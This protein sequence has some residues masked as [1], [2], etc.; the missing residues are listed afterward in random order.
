MTVSIQ[1]AATSPSFSRHAVLSAELRAAFPLARLNGEGRALRGDTLVEHLAD[2]EG[3]VI[4]LE[5]ITDEILRACP[6][7]RIV[8]KYGVGLDNID[9]EACE[10]RGVRVGWTAGSNKRSV[11]ELT[12]AYMLGLCRNV[13]V[14][15][16]HLKAGVWRK[17][18]GVQLSNRTV[19]I[20]GLGNV[21][22][23]LA[24]LLR[25]FGCTVLACDILD[26]GEWCAG[27]GVEQVEFQTLLERSDIVSLHV[28]LT[29]LTRGMIGPEALSRMRPTAILINTAR[30]EVV[31]Q[32]A[33]GQ[34][35]REHRIQAA[36]LDVYEIEPPTD[37]AFLSL[38]NLICTPHIGGS[39]DEA[40]LAMGRNAIAHL[41]RFF[42]VR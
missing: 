3:A 37:A 28:P 26:M 19:G 38:P 41:A 18:G 9:L 39:A 8:A 42:K 1:V 5:P 6:S 10:R 12:L 40:I 23:D 16:G 13:F 27:H 24:V 14:S 30:G 33:L 20:V 35:L 29:P 22:K 31:E 21:G 7:L 11:S 36:A 25:A 2:A 32:K 15:H 4:G 17:D 34:A